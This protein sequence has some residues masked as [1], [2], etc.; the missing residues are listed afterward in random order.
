MGNP[1]EN[2]PTFVARVVSMVNYF[3]ILATGLMMLHVTLDV[4]AKLVFSKPLIGTLEAVSLYYMVAIVFLPLAIVQSER[5]HISVDIIEPLVSDKANRIMELVGMIG[6]AVFS[7]LFCWRATVV[8]IAK[9][10]SNE[11]SLNLELDLLVWPGRWLPVIGFLCL[12]IVA[13]AQIVT[14]LKLK[15]SIS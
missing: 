7:I 2:L 14:R 3:S 15:K 9:T 12:A 8:A 5:S 1:E 11:Q 6:M 10:K 4:A 13:L